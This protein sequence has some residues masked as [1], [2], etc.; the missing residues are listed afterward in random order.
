MDLTQL[1]VEVDPYDI[2][3]TA[4]TIVSTERCR[5]SKL[6]NTFCDRFVLRS[7]PDL[8]VRQTSRSEH[9]GIALSRTSPAQLTAMNDADHQGLPTFDTGFR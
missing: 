4:C 6:A 5:I 2:E 8:G 9:A 1:V 3:R 7:S